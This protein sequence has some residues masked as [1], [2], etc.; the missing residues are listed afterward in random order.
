MATRWVHQL[1]G[2]FKYFL[3]SPRKL[4]KIAILTSICFRWVQ[5]TNIHQSFTRIITIIHQSHEIFWDSSKIKRSSQQAISHPLKGGVRDYAPWRSHHDLRFFPGGFG[6]T[7][8]TALVEAGYQ[9]SH[10]N[11]IYEYSIVYSIMCKLKQNNQCLMSSPD[12]YW[13]LTVY[14]CFSIGVQRVCFVSRKF[15]F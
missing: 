15:H 1:G 10:R 6:N 9:W 3:F 4:E 14:R 5:T 11:Y 13:W 7:Q 12:F 2:V 8:P